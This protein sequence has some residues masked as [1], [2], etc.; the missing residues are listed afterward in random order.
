MIVKVGGTVALICG[1]AGVTLT[2]AADQNLLFAAWGVFNIGLGL[3]V[4]LLD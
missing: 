4:L 2:L 3:S 1:I